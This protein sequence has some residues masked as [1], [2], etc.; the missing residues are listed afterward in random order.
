MA[1]VSTYEEGIEAYKNGANIISTTLSGYT[2]YS[3][4]SDEPDFE[5][6]EKLVENIDCPIILEGKIWERAQAEHAFKLG[7]HAAVVGSAITRPWLIV[8][9]FVNGK[10]G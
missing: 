9:R 7:A 2:T 3:K 8:E 4:Q 5:L 1:D 6:L 10:R